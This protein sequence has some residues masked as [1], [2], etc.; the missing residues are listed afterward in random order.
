MS[1]VIWGKKWQVYPGNSCQDKSTQIL[2][3]RLQWQQVLRIA[4]EPQEATSV[5]SFVN[6]TPPQVST[7]SNLRPLWQQN[8]SVPRWQYVSTPV[9]SQT[10]HDS[11]TPCDWS[12]ETAM[13]P[14]LGQSNMKQKVNYVNLLGKNLFF[15]RIKGWMRLP[16][17]FFKSQHPILFFLLGMKP[18]R[19]QPT[20]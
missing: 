4:L 18:R 2:T 11:M 16:V 17:P 5:G 20:Q 15:S 12:P 8:F 19:P 7:L 9:L 13:W 14:N 1:H 3:P 10:C 6:C